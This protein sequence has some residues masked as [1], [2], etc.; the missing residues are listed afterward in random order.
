M[1]L[2]WAAQEPWVAILVMMLSVGFWIVSSLFKAL[3]EPPRQV[4]PGA[5]ANP[6]GPPA[7]RT[8]M[9]L[10]EFLLE[11]RRRRSA[12]EANAPP[13]PEQP[14]VVKPKD[15]LPEG[16]SRRRKPRKNPVQSIVQPPPPP[17]E[18]PPA[19]L[20]PDP[21]A[22]TTPPKQEAIG[23]PFAEHPLG[24]F[25]RS[26]LANPATLPG[27]LILGEVLGPPRSRGKPPRSR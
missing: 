9:S 1:N 3:M 7:P 26:T 21:I 12:S 11:A 15:R 20:V 27:A 13:P 8:P 14:V 23:K 17:A 5:G 18:P 10:E 22:M 4:K 16:G 6:G 25:M 19:I 24:A 2:P